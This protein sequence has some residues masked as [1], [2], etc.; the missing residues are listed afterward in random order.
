MTLTR[1]TTDEERENIVGV[2]V[3]DEDLAAV[4]DLVSKGI[5][6]A[7]QRHEDAV[8]DDMALSVAVSIDLSRPVRGESG[9]PEI[10]SSDHM[11]RTRLTAQKHYANEDLKPVVE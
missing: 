9:E 7:A 5:I 8:Q 2:T 1:Y 11:V 10:F 3:K 4:L 6:Q